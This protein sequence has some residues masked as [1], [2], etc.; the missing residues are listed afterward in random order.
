MENMLSWDNAPIILT[1][2]QTGVLLGLSADT[3]RKRCIK[4]KLPATQIGKSW[5]IDKQKLMEQIN[6]TGV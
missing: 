4:K 2:K 3:I 5:R 1:A 6:N